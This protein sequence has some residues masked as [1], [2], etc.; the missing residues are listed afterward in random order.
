MARWP[1]H[2]YISHFSA[3]ACAWVWHAHIH[4]FAQIG[5]TRCTYMSISRFKAINTL[6]FLNLPW[7]PFILVMYE[8][9][10]VHQVKASF[11]SWKPRDSPFPFFGFLS[12]CQA[13]SE[14]W[15]LSA[16]QHMVYWYIAMGPVHD[17]LVRSN[18]KY[19]S[20]VSIL[21]KCLLYIFRNPKLV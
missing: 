10:M 3:C 9:N 14:I 17:T 4:G 6:Q 21:A 8:S 20:L 16:Y 15:Y 13:F 11:N 18:H 2:G 1:T 5:M 12:F 19:L 7:C